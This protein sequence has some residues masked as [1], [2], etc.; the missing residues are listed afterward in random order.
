MND[1]ISLYEN[2]LYL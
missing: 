1:V 2:S